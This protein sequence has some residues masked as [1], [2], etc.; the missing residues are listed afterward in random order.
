MNFQ[1]TFGEFVLVR[2]WREKEKKEIRKVIRY[3]KVVEL[4]CGYLSRYSIDFGSTF[5]IVS[6]LVD[7]SKKGF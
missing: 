2:V 3:L 1:L 4:N 5:W 7:S 6:Q